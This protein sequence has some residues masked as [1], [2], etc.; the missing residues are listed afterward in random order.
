LALEDLEGCAK[1]SRV[2]VGSVI[3]GAIVFLEPYEGELGEWIV[4]VDFDLEKILSSR[5]EIL[6]FGRYSLISRP[7]SNTASASERTTC[8]VK[9]H[10]ESSSARVLRSAI[11]ER[12]GVK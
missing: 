9:S 6:Y 11:R 10:T 1:G 3:A 8:K 12:A 7:S 5:N 2:R 4:E